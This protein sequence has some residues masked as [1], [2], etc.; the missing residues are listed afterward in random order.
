MDRIIK[1]PRAIE[2]TDVESGKY[3]LETK[4]IERVISRNGQSLEKFTFLTLSGPSAGVLITKPFPTNGFSSKYLVDFIAKLLPDFQGSEI[5][6]DE[7][8][9][10]SF[11]AKVT[12]KQIKDSTT[13]YYDIEPTSK[14]NEATE[15]R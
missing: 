11:S 14:L 9:G 12:R 4:S 15:E 2:S 7:L 1:L 6:Y 3:S 10:K 5:S 8:I 13:I